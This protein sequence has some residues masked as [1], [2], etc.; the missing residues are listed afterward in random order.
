MW[1]RRTL[2]LL[3]SPSLAGFGAWIDFLAILTL[4]A[5]A[6]EADAFVM[7]L[8]SALFLVPAI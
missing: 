2:G 8:V 4:A 1:N 7:A 5:Y 6:Y 3:A